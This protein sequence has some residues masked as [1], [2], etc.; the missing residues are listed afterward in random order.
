[1]TVSGE[2]ALRAELEQL[3]KVDRPRITQAISAFFSTSRRTERLSMSLTLITGA[4][5]ALTGSLKC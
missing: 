5:M 3:K 4:M 2:A 1:M